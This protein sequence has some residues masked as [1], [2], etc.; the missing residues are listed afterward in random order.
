MRRATR[1]ATATAG[2]L[3][4]ALGVAACGSDDDDAAST[5]TAAVGTDGEQAAG[6]DAFCDGLIDFNGAATSLEIDDT[7]P[8]EEVKAA[9]AELAEIFAPVRDNAPED[10][11]DTATELAQIVDDLKA[12]DAESFSSDASFELYTSFVSSAGEVCPFEEVAVTGVDYAFEGVPATISSGSKTFVFTNDSEAEQH[13]MIIIRRNDGVDLTFEEIANLPEEETEDMVQF[14]GAAFAPP[15]GESSTLGMLSPGDYAMFCFIPVGGG[16][17][18][19][20][21]FTQG[22]LQE[23]TVE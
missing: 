18:G 23:F 2:V 8:D 7:T 1:T 14:I 11:S 4:L 15:G 19:P 13:E 21:H 5:T 9:G 3:L 10:L 16:E 17:D 6:I 12:G 20:P 22:M